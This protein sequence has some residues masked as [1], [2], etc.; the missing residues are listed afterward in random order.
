MKLLIL[1]LMTVSTA[2]VF[3]QTDTVVNHSDSLGRKQGFWTTQLRDRHDDKVFALEQYKDG[4]KHGICLYYYPDGV[5]KE[6][7]TY[8]NGELNGCSVLYTSDGMIAVEASYKNGNLHGVKRVFNSDERLVEESE[9]NNGEKLYTRF[10][11]KG[12]VRS[13]ELYA[14]NNY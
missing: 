6:K 2:G 1:L 13:T 9:F 10:Y 3:G 7:R 4:L 12:R 14:S 5:R 11:R 8:R